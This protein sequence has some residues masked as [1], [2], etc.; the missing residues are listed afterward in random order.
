[1]RGL[2]AQ[3]TLIATGESQKRLG[4]FGGLSGVNSIGR[5]VPDLTTVASGTDKIQTTTSQLSNAQVDHLSCSPHNDSL[6]LTGDTEEIA[7]WDI[8]NFSKALFAIKNG[9]AYQM[10]FS[11]ASSNFVWLSKES[12]VE[13]LSLVDW[14]PMDTSESNGIKV[15]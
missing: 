2:G 3:A 6:F 4:G 8:R 7:F 9:P 15:G 5:T 10:E 11:N 13:A 14:K 1:M 12:S